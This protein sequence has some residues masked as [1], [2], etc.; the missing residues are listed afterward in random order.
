MSH[1]VGSKRAPHRVERLLVYAEQFMQ[2]DEETMSV[3]ERR[4]G[5]V[6]LARNASAAVAAR[7]S[8]ARVGINWILTV[9]LRVRVPGCTA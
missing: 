9:G 8:D 7:R 2:H 4:T 6:A 3:A 5:N 1:D